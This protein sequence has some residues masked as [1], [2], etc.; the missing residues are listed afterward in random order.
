M[1]FLSRFFGVTADTA[2]AAGDLAE[3][4]ST[5]TEFLQQVA[6]KI[7]DA[8]EK[9]GDL[10]DRLP[11]VFVDWI[12]DGAP[13]L[14]AGGDALG[15]AVPPI[16][17]ILSIVK[18]I[19][20]EPDPKILGLIAVSVAYQAALA[21]AAKQLQA[22]ASLRERIKL[23]RKLPKKLPRE[24]LGK[25]EDEEAFDGFQLATALSHPLVLKAD[26]ALQK[27]AEAAGFP[28]DVVRLL[29]E[30]VHARFSDKFRQAISH[31]DAKEKFDPLFRLMNMSGPEF[32]MYA[33][34]KRHMDFQIWRFTLAPALGG[35][36]SMSLDT[37]LARI[38]V[39]LDCGRLSWGE[40]RNPS[41]HS[42]QRAG[43]LD[44]FNEEFG[45]RQPLL[46]TVMSLI[47]EMNFQDAIIVQG[48]AG[49]GKSAFTQ[50]LCKALRDAALRP[51]RVRMRDLSL[52]PRISL[53]DDVAAALRVSCGDD[54][55]DK[56]A[57]A[58][59]N[60]SNVS[61]QSIL[62][63]VVPFG[64][65]RICPYVLI[66]DGWDE[67]SIS[68]SEGFRI[69]I[70]KTLNA[71]RTQLLAGRSH[72]V[73]VILT[74]RP[75]E[76]VNE[77]K[78]LLDETPVLT[79]RPFNDDQLRTFVDGLLTARRAVIEEAALEEASGRANALIA[80]IEGP[81]HISEHD[82]NVLRLP[83]LALLAVWLVLN[84]PD[85]P[86]DLAV[87]RTSLYKRLVELTTRYGGSV[88]QLPGAANRVVGG[89]LRELLQRTASA[90]TV[91]GVEHIS[92][93]DL[94]L[95]LE[96]GGLDD[97]DVAVEH[98]AS[99]NVVSKLMLS[100]FFNPGSREHGCEFSHKSFREYLFAE[101]VVAVLKRNAELPGGESRRSPYW[102][103][104]AESDPR[105]AL[106]EELGPMFGSQ[107]IRPE[108][109]RHLAWL[110]AWEIECA[111]AG[112]SPGGGEAPGSMSAWRAIRDRLVDLWDWWAEGVH[113]RPQ[114][115][116]LK[117]T[118]KIDFRDP[119][120]LT[121]AKQITPMDAPR[122]LLP[123]PL[124]LVS[125]DSHLGD[126]LFR[127]NCT[128]HFEINKSTGWLDRSGA[129]GSDLAPLIWKGAQRP[130]ASGRLYQTKIE[131]EGGIWWAFAPAT[132]DGE[133]YYFLNYVSR[134]NAAGW[135]PDGQFPFSVN[136]SGVDLSDTDL[137][138]LAF[139]EAVFDNA[140]LSDC[141]ASA[142]V[143]EE[144]SFHATLFDSG[145]FLGCI[146]VDSKNLK[147]AYFGDNKLKSTIFW[148]TN[149]HYPNESDFPN[150][151]FYD[152]RANEKKDRVSITELSE[153]SAN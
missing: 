97:P 118:K 74:G 36:S 142:V 109:W 52:D 139:N 127:L 120:A 18:Y 146:F 1:S 72:R 17:A 117:G 42:H 26:V 115:F 85:P 30:G 23:F 131:A 59:P 9:A 121:I 32:T 132:P 78:F 119:L 104:F 105:R 29:L 5:T 110:I 76:D 147:D 65:A 122:G 88:E 11:D 133:N 15:E 62:D 19:T 126:A 113:M 116:R 2:D 150:S 84:D 53:M 102:A 69:R 152:P 7:P 31:G 128:V 13:W 100:F 12:Q 89:G 63:E 114:P 82:R 39:P 20:R 25:A 106:V 46:G 125:I 37:P 47:G 68:A 50:H 41:P 151:F 87:G 73:R 14:K 8:V 108:V 86:R 93:E 81:T 143:F 24:A 144:C 45:G 83:L 16:K 3:K 70:E 6:D 137:K 91:R 90:M 136:M 94:V 33:L 58:R 27:V 4:V 35:G 75:S 57:G 34:L 101:A 107:W 64:G 40:I 67:I 38:F 98:A 66:F 54:D 51:L 92:Y 135:R 61:I 112:K 80:P 22:D 56:I 43:R 21:D 141:D 55:F 103:E 77:A 153:P 10:A 124:R 48:V 28:D 60:F 49:A 138:G 71:V 140:C 129:K 148:K 123:E 96:A 95:S 130:K 79:V 149:G 99:E 111:A 145:T 134:I 44:V